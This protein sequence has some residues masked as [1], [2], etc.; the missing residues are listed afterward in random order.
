[1]VHLC[2]MT[3]GHRRATEP[4]AALDRVF[5][6]KRPDVTIE[7]RDRP[8]SGFEFDPMDML[9]EE[10]DLIVYD[11][12]FCGL[13]D[14]TE[15]LLSVIDI[16]AEEGGSAAFVGP[17][18]QTYRY[19]HGEWA[20]PVDAAC[21]IAA[22]RPDL[23]ARL[24]RPVPKT[25]DDVC[26]LAQ[27]SAEKDMTVAI[28]LHG[29]HSLMTFFSL[30]ANLGSPY[31]TDDAGPDS[32]NPAVREALAQMRR[33]VSLCKAPV[34]DWNS[35]AV[36]DALV[37]SENLV[38]CPAVYGFATF[39][40]ADCANRLAFG[41]F[42]GLNADAP[43]AGSTIGGAGLGVSYRVSRDPELKEAALAYARL[44]ASASAQTTVF[45]QHHGQPAHMAAWTDPDID[46]AF[47]GFFSDTRTTMEQSWIRPRYNGYLRFQAE[48]GDMIEAHLRGDLAEAKLLEQLN[49]LEA[50][51]R[52]GRP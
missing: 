16:V 40:E 14:Q 7:W 2:G 10:N 26:A 42:P 11:H 19:G 50:A 5:R 8:L 37:G 9:A 30:C 51:C 25:W 13:I 49:R 33:L 43:A 46:A 21:Q 45:P 52:D 3:W 28:G 15:C 23:L 48:A 35:I 41:P 39:G 20:V 27:I 31:A 1:M 17:S 47:N 32:S 6:N 18:A 34:L 36:Q 29:V 24:D 12:P 38:Y 22:Y 4:L 44:A